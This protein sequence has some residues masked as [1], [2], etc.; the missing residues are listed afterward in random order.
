[1][2]DCPG[3]KLGLA[4]PTLNEAGNIGALL[5]GLHDA[6]SSVPIDY[7]LIVVDDDSKDD[8]AEVARQYGSSD[9]RVR[10]FTR[11]GKRG[12]AGAVMYGWEQTDANLLGVID[13]D[14]QHPP[15]VLPRLLEPVMNGND[16]AIAS[17]YV[18]SKD[19][20][21]G[22][23]N[24]V[25]ALVSR[26]G[27]LAT[28]PLQKKNMRIRDPLSGFFVV[29]RECIDGLE[30][31]PEGFKILLEIL[32]RGRVRRPTEVP[33]HFGVRHAGKSKANFR[34][35]LAYFNLLGKLSRHALFGPGQ[36]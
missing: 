12:L 1:M 3:F 21:L 28:A 32:V 13:A 36:R 14:L 16:L 17:R 11:Q 20:G 2:N 35:A 15:E 25:R 9:P 4:I 29:R 24:W 26:C 6:M 31:Q 27:T 22:D 18:S 23:W 7:E 5:G 34:V 30:L 33:F 8:T 10:V 19:N